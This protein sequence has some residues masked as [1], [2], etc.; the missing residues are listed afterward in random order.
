VLDANSPTAQP[1]TLA[2][3]YA[4]YSMLRK[5]L[6][7]RGGDI[8]ENDETDVHIVKVDDPLNTGASLKRV[9]AFRR[10]LATANFHIAQNVGWHDQ[11]TNG[12]GDVHAGLVA[13]ASGAFSGAL[14]GPAAPAEVVDSVM[15]YEQGLRFAQTYVFGVGALD[16][17]GARGGPQHLSDE[18]PSQREKQ[19][20]QRERHIVRHRRIA[21]KIP[22]AR[23]AALYARQR[24]HGRGT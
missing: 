22:Q 17:C 13:Q 12:T 14:G 24:R 5:G 21:R 20:Q 6:F 23:H 3:K 7:R 2:Q 1:K 4:A 11:N 19:R 15:R 18:A 10:P 8:P 16:S 9:Q